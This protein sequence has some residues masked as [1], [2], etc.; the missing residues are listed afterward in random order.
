[1]GIIKNPNESTTYRELDLS[2]SVDIDNFIKNLSNPRFL[3]S[4]F[5]R[6]DQIKPSNSFLG[7]LKGQIFYNNIVK[8]GNWILFNPLVK[9]LIILWCIFNIIMFV[10]L[11]I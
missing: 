11:L 5:R 7:I 9:A 3:G 4:N 1:M 2:S 8:K 6:R 10:L